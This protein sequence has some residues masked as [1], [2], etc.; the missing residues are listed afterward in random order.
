M[1][2]QHIHV[3]L[4]PLLT[5]VAGALP[6][7]AAARGHDGHVARPFDPDTLAADEQDQAGGEEA[8]GGD[9]E[10]HQED[11]LGGHQVISSDHKVWCVRGVETGKS[12]H[13]EM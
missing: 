3:K 7:P 1:L 12:K 13:F 8:A 11:G 5:T 10:E 2:P 9:G 6:P 4:F